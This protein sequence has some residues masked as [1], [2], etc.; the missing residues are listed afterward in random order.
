[1]AET[2][3]EMPNATGTPNTPNTPNANNTNGPGGGPN[4]GGNQ[5]NATSLIDPNFSGAT[6]D[7]QAG[8]GLVFEKILKKINPTVTLKKL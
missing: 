3:A 8:I 4:N 7:L 1:M 5:N 2:K 6:P